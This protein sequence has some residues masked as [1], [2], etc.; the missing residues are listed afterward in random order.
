MVKQ[1]YLQS[2]SEANEIWEVQF[3][4]LRTYHN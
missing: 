1:V 2:S 4:D 3:I